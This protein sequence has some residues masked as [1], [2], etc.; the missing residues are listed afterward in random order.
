M[1]DDASYTA[2]LEKANADV[3]GPSHSHEQSPST[4]QARTK[5]DPTTS[6]TS[7][8]EALPASLKSLPSDLTYTSDTD[9]PFQP[10]ALNYAG[11]ELP[12]A[13]EFRKCLGAKGQ[14]AGA[15]EELSAE[16]FDPRGQYKDIIERV[17]QAAKE[18]NLKVKVYRVEISRTRAEYYI[19]TLGEKMLVGVYVKAV[20]S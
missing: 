16:E 17:S 6:T 20:E 3:S 19:L 7:Q 8:L 14:T 10:I 5:L 13:E 18:Q 4:S 1:A 9:E 15:V 11:T 12:N 2:F